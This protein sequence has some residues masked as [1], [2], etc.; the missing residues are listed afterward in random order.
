MLDTE[1]GPLP[2]SPL[3]FKAPLQTSNVQAINGTI[4]V[5]MPF[6]KQSDVKSH[7]SSRNRNRLHLNPDAGPPPEATDT[8]LTGPGTII[9]NTAAF[10]E[11]YFAEHAPTGQSAPLA[12]DSNDSTDVQP[13]EASKSPQ[14]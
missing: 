14:S 1:V 13:S 3:A 7:F 2:F 9:A 11:D 5:H 6:N 8:S 12:T 4:G 10:A